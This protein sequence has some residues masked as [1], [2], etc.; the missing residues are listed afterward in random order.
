MSL[1]SHTRQQL[2]ALGHALNPVVT[3]AGKGLADSVLD[4]VRRALHDHELIKVKFA[5]GD[6]VAK[7]QI[8]ADMCAR[9]ECEL[10]QQ[11]G[12][13]ALVYKK[14]P[15]AKLGLSNIRNSVE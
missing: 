2:K 10:V 13:I 6:R 1:D 9:C 12:H 4:E 3:V 8:I 14:N 15:Q 7:Q 11:I 5:V